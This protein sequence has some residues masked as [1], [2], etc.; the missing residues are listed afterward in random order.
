MESIPQLEEWRMIEEPELVNY[1]ISKYPKV[2]VGDKV[3]IFVKGKGNY[4]SRKES[5]NQWI[6]RTYEVKEVGRDGQLNKHHILDGLSKNYNRHEIL[7]V[8]D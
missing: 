6:E 1:Y 5:R 7:L 8:D 4:T 3:K 2:E